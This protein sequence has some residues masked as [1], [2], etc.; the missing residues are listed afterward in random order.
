MYRMSLSPLEI[1]FR[2]KGLRTICESS[3]HARK[4][5]GDAAPA[6]RHRLADMRAATTVNDLVAAKPRELPDR[7]NHFAIDLHHRHR[8]V[9]CPNHRI[10]PVD[11]AG[12]VDWTRVTRVQIVDILGQP[13][14]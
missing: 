1:S 8:L 6:L 4:Q 5:M 10:N 2:T 13:N 9:F 7:A 12:Q 11:P 14:D 3:T